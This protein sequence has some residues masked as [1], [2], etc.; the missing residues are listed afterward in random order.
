[1]A[2]KTELSRMSDVACQSH[3][4]CTTLA[5]TKWRTHCR[6]SGPLCL[7]SPLTPA[8]CRAM[9]WQRR[10]CGECG[11]RENARAKK[12][13]DQSRPTLT[14]KKGQTLILIRFL[15][16]FS[17]GPHTE[18]LVRARS[19]TCL[20]ADN[21]RPVVSLEM[22]GRA[23][24]HMNMGRRVAILT[25]PVDSPSWQPSFRVMAPSH[26]SGHRCTR[27]LSCCLALTRC[28]CC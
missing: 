24:L 13:Q 28:H 10:R 4:D 1:M 20:H 16:Y 23:R 8:T 15:S 2:E 25:N 14:A 3:S 7:P 26:G 17:S 9:P 22:S 19:H 5:R 12:K 27:R 21:E 11:G 6:P 18:G